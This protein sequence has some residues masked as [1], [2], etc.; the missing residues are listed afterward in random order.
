M[1]R[2]AVALLFVLGWLAAGAAQAEQIRFP[3]TGTNAFLIDLPAGWTAKEDQYNGIQLLPA[4]HRTSVYLSVVLDKQYEGKPIEELAL[5]IGKPS[6]ITRFSRREPAAISGLKGAAFYAQAEKRQRR[7]AGRQDGHH[8]AGAGAVGDRDAAELAAIKRRAGCRAQAGR[9]R[10]R[11]HHPITSSAGDTT[12][13][14]TTIKIA[15]SAGG[16]FDCYLATPQAA[17]AAPAV[18]L[19]SAVHGVDKDIRDLADAFAAAGFIAAA[20]DLFWRSVP[21]PLT[22]ADEERA[23]QR[24]QPRLEKIKTGEAD[25]AD[26]L[27]P[28]AS[29]AVQR[30]R[31]GDGLLLRRPLRD[32][33]AEAARLRRR[34]LLPRHHML[35]FID[36]LEGLAAPVCIIWGDQDH[37]APPE[38]L[39][40][41]R[42]VRGAHEERRAAHFSRRAARLHDARHRPLRRQDARVLDGARARDPRRPARRRRSAAQ[43]VVSKEPQ[44]APNVRDNTERHRFE[45]D[46]DGHVAFSN[47]K[48]DGAT[49][50][51]SCTP[52][53]RRNST[54]GASARRWRAACSTSCARKASRWWR[55]APSSPAYIAKHPEYADLLR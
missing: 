20:P 47:Y 6:Q 33:R 5:A 50:S 19:A 37:A 10:D 1:R 53:F 40:A 21:G 36:E 12:M 45:L 11:G 43:R 44:H 25:M 23:G 22:R 24:S 29:A 7:R 17:G 18:V 32:P 13:P 3:K 16:E 34:H 54:A 31:R 4:D 38:V 41:Y 55:F 30:P 39:A 2:H 51:P 52:R 46:A 28:C 27:A 15:A 8:S 49:S 14:A 26:T 42:A 9:E 48:R 35:D